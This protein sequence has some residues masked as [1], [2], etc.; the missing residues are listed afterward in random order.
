MNLGWTC[1]KDRRVLTGTSI[2]RLAV[3]QDLYIHGIA[4]HCFTCCDLPQPYIRTT[5]K[6]I[7]LWPL[8]WLLV[9]CI[10]S[11]RYPHQIVQPI[12]HGCRG[13]TVYTAAAICPHSNSSNDCNSQYSHSLSQAQWQCTQFSSEDAWPYS[14]MGAGERNQHP[15]PMDHLYRSLILLVCLAHTST[16]TTLFGQCSDAQKTVTLK[17]VVEY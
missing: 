14:V 11:F 6:S 9:C 3:Q 15:I 4:I 2:S 12:P 10:C 8:L 13:P 7:S 5:Y 1:K 17:K 16:T